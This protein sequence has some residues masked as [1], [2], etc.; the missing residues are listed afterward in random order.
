MKCDLR[1]A[2]HLTF[3]LP[4]FVALLLDGGCRVWAQANQL[5]KQTDDQGV[6]QADEPV[7]PNAAD[8]AERKRTEAAYQ[9]AQRERI[10]ER[11]RLLDQESGKAWVIKF[12]RIK[13]TT[14]RCW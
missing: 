2:R 10:A 7:K 11:E 8:E 3:T 1:G 9:L 14:A 5:P 13:W 4:I 12:V 6:A